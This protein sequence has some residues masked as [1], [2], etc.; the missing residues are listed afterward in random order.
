MSGSSQAVVV[1]SSQGGYVSGGCDATC[2]CAPKCKKHI[3]CP[4]KKH[5]HAMIASSVVLPSAQSIV[6]S[7]EATAPCKIKKPCFL[8]TWLHHKAGCKNKACKGCNTCTYCGEPA[9][10]VPAQGAI[11][12]P[13]L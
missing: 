7:C 11:V 12:S 10:M 13:Q 9:V 2:G 4:F 1:T 3:L 5:K 6:S 8:K